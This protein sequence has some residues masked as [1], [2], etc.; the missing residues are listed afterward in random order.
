MVIQI[1]LSSFCVCSPL[2]ISC[3]CL[4]LCCC[5]WPCLYIAF[6]PFQKIESFCG[7]D[8]WLHSVL[9]SSHHS[10]FCCCCLSWLLFLLNCIDSF[11]WPCIMLQ[12]VVVGGGGHD[13][14]GMPQIP[15]TAH[16]LQTADNI[17]LKTVFI[18]I[19]QP[20]CCICIIFL[21]IC[22]LLCAW[23]VPV[24]TVYGHVFS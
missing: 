11:L 19:L 17:I 8:I 13:D 3:L 20:Y 24:L 10:C 16:V 7:G 23:Y 22:I 14:S 15:V 12:G 21:F 4:A 9:I 5:F 1:S 6:A 2:L 18:I